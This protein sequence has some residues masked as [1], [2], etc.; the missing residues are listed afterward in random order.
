M[1]AGQSQ[2]A[3]T[4]SSKAAVPGWS[5]EHTVVGP[6]ASEGCRKKADSF[7]MS[8][9]TQPPNSTEAGG[10]KLATQ[11]VETTESMSTGEGLGSSSHRVKRASVC[12]AALVESAPTGGRKAAAHGCGWGVQSCPLYLGT[13]SLATATCRAG[14]G[15]CKNSSVCGITDSR[16]CSLT[17]GIG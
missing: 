13:V 17:C 7:A 3:F 15:V 16:L 14:R 2:E 6:L 11:L 10:R 5:P 9:S 8:S 12:S 4:N 1:E